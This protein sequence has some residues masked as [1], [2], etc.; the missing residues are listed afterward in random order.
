MYPQVMRKEAL[1]S[2]VETDSSEIMAEMKLADEY[3][4][5]V[6]KETEDTEEASADANDADE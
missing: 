1:M 4:A 2:E 6:A 5:E 3:N